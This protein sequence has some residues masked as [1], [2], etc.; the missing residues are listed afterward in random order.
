[1][2]FLTLKTIRSIILEELQ[3][4]D[5]KIQGS[6][7]PGSSGTFNIR[8]DYDKALSSSDMGEDIVYSQTAQEISD[9]Y[10]ITEEEAQKIVEISERLN[11]N[12]GWISKIIDVE[13][14]GTWDPA[15]PNKAGSGATGLIQFMPTTAEGLG[16]STSELA[17]MTIIEQLDYVEKYFEPYTGRL[18]SME[19]VAAAVFF[20]AAL[21]Q[22]LDF[23]IYD[24]YVT[25]R[26]QSDANVFRDQNPNII[27]MGDYVRSFLS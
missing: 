27:T 26:G 7:Q 24:W 17:R 2:E 12:P 6:S 15:E 5:E 25:N 21:D 10:G 16:T 14:G 11:T 13:T 23:N 3:R 9:E 22:G 18:N 4:V 19:D 1:M 20:P 8:V